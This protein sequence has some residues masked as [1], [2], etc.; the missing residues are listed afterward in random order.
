MSIMRWGA[1][2]RSNKM[3]IRDRDKIAQFNI[4]A[5]EELNVFFDVDASEWNGRWFKSIRAWKVERVGAQG[6]VA[7]SYTHL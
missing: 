7:V 3:C 6:P 5:G 1:G 2:P 4:Q